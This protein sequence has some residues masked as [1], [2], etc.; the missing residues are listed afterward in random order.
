MRDGLTEVN[1]TASKS[2]SGSSC[3]VEMGSIA[4]RKKE[5][6]FLDVDWLI[7]QLCSAK[8]KKSSNKGGGNSGPYN[9][10]EK[11]KSSSNVL[12]ARRHSVNICTRITDEVPIKKTTVI[13][14]TH[15]L[16]CLNIP[17]R[18]ELGSQKILKLRNC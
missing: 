8:E 11:Q 13:T 12:P 7:S 9:F 6:G 5:S 10:V 4:E 16:M 1:Q 17:V 2:S 14:Q 15:I 18:L 3:C